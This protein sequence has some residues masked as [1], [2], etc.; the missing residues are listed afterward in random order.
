M[1]EEAER[2]RARKWGEWNMRMIS[3]PDLKV[4]VP[5]PNWGAGGVL[6]FLP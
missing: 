1:E 4:K 2:G 3:M 5:Y 6:I